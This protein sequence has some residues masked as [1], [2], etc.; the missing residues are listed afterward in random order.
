MNTDEHGWTR[1]K[2][3]GRILTELKIFHYS[4]IEWGP[5]ICD[6]FSVNVTVGEP[7]SLA[8]AMGEWGKLPA[9]RARVEQKV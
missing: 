7:F 8:R 6:L 3:H 4:S 5:F 9:R 2:I 1:I